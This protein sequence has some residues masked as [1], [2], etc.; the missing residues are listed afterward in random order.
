MVA[1]PRLLPETIPVLRP[2]VAIVVLLLVHV[3]PPASVN[4]DVAPRHT[5]ILPVI[6]PGDETTFTVVV[7]I[8]PFG[9]V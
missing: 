6:A 2:T 8:Q 3:P 5:L 7:A 1:V 9:S 4:A